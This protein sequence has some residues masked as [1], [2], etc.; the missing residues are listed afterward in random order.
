MRRRLWLTVA[1]AGLG[2]SAVAAVWPGDSSRA[3]PA[4]SGF[5][6]LSPSG[7]ARVGAARTPQAVRDGGGP[8]VSTLEPSVTPPLRDA[9]GVV[10]YQ[11][12][13]FTIPEPERR[14]R[15]TTG[16]SAFADPVRQI[17]KGPQLMPS[18]TT[19]D[20]LTQT[21]GCLPPDD[22]GDV[23]PN[24]YVEWINTSIAVYSKSGVLAAG[25]PKNGNA[26]WAGFGGL[27]Q[28]ANQGDPLVQYDQLAD[29]WVFSQFAFTSL[30]SR[31]YYQCIAISQTNDPTGAYCDYAFQ[32]PQN[33]SGDANFNDYAKMGV[34]PDAYYFGWPQYLDGDTFD[35]A[36]AMAIDRAKML[37]CLP[38]QTVYFD[39]SQTPNATDAAVPLP[40]DLDGSAAPPAGSPDYYVESEDTDV[41][42]APADRIRVWK[43]HVDWT[44]T[45][46]STFTLG[47]TL[48][49]APFTALCATALL[50]TENCIPQL[51]GSSSNQL[52]ALGDRPMYRAAYRNF[53]DHEAL[54]FDHTVDA[55]GGVAGIRWYELRGLS[56][57]PSIFQQSTYAPDSTHRWLGSAAM[58][59]AGDLAI[60][61]S[62][63]SSAIYPQIRYAGRLASDPLNALGQGE[64][65]LFSGGGRQTDPSGRWGDYSALSVDPIDGCTFWYVNEYYATTGGANWRTRIGNFKFSQCSRPTAATVVRFATRRAKAGVVVTWRTGTEA[66][67]LGFNLFR[68]GRR[69]APTMIRAKRSGQAGGAAYR[70]VDPAA[71]KLATYRLQLVDLAGKRTWYAIGSAAPGR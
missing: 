28:T 43:F 63:S 9:A 23:G 19:F 55:G 67:V 20:G 5:V 37:A 11:G 15:S 46:N 14:S 41:D 17:V 70:F 27:C 51:G 35:G 59:A 61:F 13:V 30:T 44:N 47:A 49:V 54:V 60:G 12:P 58:D 48:P 57:T 1:A 22:D 6:R 36:G 25:F 45:A 65:T 42:S 21:C 50:Y 38:A 68:N 32:L 2:A 18:A 71:P 34:W 64:A 40:S 16:A 39:L 8:I 56:G 53:G 31:P 29:R 3:I 33:A 7:S 24:N 62:A 69:L 4:R 52:D 66:R 10:P 26:L